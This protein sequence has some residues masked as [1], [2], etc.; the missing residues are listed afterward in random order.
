VGRNV[1]IKARLEDFAA[2]RRRVAE[3]ADS[4]PT[5]ILQE[6]VFFESRRGRLKLRKVS[7]IQAELIHYERPNRREPGPSSYVIARCD[8]PEPLQEA[9]SRA[10]G[11]RGVVRKER[12]VYLRGRTRIHLDRVVELGD[13]LELEVVLEQDEEQDKAIREAEELMRALAIDQK[14]L[15]ECAYIDLL[16]SG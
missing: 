15:V 5:V 13:F 3:L 14:T 16:S 4:G 12:E 7:G 2:T 9:L 1:E 6:D 11:V 8:A 10:L